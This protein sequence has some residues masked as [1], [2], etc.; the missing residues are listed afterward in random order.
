MH[1]T[2]GAGSG[3]PPQPWQSG[4]VKPG[5]ASRRTAVGCAGSLWPNGS[6]VRNVSPAWA[7]CPRTSKTPARMSPDWSPVD[8]ALV[9]A[10]WSPGDAALVTAG[11]D[12]RE[13]LGAQGV[14][15]NVASGD[16]AVLD[17]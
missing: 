7:A 2:P 6:V 1:R 14:V 8:A 3:S 5:L 12:P 13:V 11:W 9:T 16:A 10:G 4:V 17:L 15:A